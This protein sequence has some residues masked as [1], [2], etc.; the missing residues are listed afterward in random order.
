MKLAG[1]GSLAFASNEFLIPGEAKQ[2]TV[3]I[4]N[5]FN[6]IPVSLIIDDSTCLVNMAYY[7]SLSSV[8]FFLTN[9]SRTGENYPVRFPI[10]LSGNLVSGVLRTG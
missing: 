9:I 1:A 8:R 2:L 7:G 6:R 10:V 5:P 4:L 3:T